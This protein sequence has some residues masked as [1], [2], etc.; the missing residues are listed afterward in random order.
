[1]NADGNNW[2]ASGFAT[3]MDGAIPSMEGARA[4]ICSPGNGSVQ[5]YDFTTFGP[6]TLVE[7]TA[8]LWN[9]SVAVRD[10]TTYCSFS[11]SFTE[12]GSALLPPAQK[13]IFALGGSNQFDDKTQ[14]TK[15]AGVIIDLM[16]GKVH[17][18][19]PSTD[20]SMCS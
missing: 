12:Q 5:E 3:Q 4:V 14:H 9:T 7:T 20:A 18:L 11:R 15:D 19:H 10:T 6:G 8:D 13:M 2:V 16:A 17:L 1:M